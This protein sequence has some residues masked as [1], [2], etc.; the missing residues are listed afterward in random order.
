MKFPRKPLK[1]PVTFL[2]S[3]DEQWNKW[4]LTRTPSTPFRA[5]FCSQDNFKTQFL[6]ELRNCVVSSLNANG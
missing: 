3:A 1:V 4:I 5:H 6:D 2:Q